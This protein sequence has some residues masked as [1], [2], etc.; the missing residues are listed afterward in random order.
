[1]LFIPLADLEEEGFADYRKLFDEQYA[2]SENR[3]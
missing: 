2:S 3:K 1:V